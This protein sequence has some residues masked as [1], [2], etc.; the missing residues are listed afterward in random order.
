MNSKLWAN[1][2][3]RVARPHTSRAGEKSTHVKSN[4][5]DDG[6]Q[7]AGIVDDHNGAHGQAVTF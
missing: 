4:L 2:N 3:D 1:A 7:P 6:V 5:L